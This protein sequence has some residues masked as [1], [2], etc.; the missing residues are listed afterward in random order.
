MASIYIHVSMLT[1]RCIYLV[2]NQLAKEE[3]VNIVPC[4]SRY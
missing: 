1:E 2:I 3:Q 4:F